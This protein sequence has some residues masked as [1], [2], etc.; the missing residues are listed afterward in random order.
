MRLLDALSERSGRQVG[1]IAQLSGLAPD[2]IRAQLGLLELEGIVHQ[3]AAGWQK[4]SVKQLDA[5]R[6]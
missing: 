2:R 5:Q 1:R 3:G 6:R 4:F